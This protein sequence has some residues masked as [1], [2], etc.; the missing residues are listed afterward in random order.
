MNKQLL[1]RNFYNKF[2]KKNIGFWSVAKGIWV[3]YFL[4]EKW[5]FN[6][7]F[8]NGWK[9]AW[10][11]SCC[12]LSDNCT[13]VRPVSRCQVH[14]GFINPCKTVYFYAYVQAYT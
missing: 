13:A 12:H 14:T 6:I 3:E 4:F 7:L 5:P 1:H 9:C 2:R 8:K 10:T 11:K